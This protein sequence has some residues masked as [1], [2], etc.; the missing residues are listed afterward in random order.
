MREIKVVVTLGF[1]ALVIWV[2]VATQSI[3]ELAMRVEVLESKVQM[4]EK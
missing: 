3:K 1:L 4:G 2:A